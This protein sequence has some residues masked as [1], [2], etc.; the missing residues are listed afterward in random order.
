[1]SPLRK[2]DPVII[3]T[4]LEAGEYNCD[5][6]K[7]YSVKPASI[8]KAARDAGYV[9]RDCPTR[10]VKSARSHAK[11]TAEQRDD[12][13]KRVSEGEKQVVLAREYGISRP[14]VSI[15]IKRY[16]SPRVAP[17]SRAGDGGPEA[18][19]LVS[20]PPLSQSCEARHG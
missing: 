16:G 4:R 18:S 17:V 5:L 14:R 15:I 7:E 20:G 9:W 2:L 1:M 11:T 6:A 12:I 8:S 10:R 13:V 19:S 3:R